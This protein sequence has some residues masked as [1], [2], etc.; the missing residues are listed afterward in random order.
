MPSS[1][2][3]PKLREIELHP[4]AWDRFENFVKKNVPNRP[5]AKTKVSRPKVTSRKRAKK[6]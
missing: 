1:T 4:D 3:K 2:K 6:A 5:P